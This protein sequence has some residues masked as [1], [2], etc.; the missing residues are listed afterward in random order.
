M[1]VSTA[2]VGFAAA[3]AAALSAL[4][5]AAAGDR[6]P[7]VDR[8]SRTGL[9]VTR[10]LSVAEGLRA[11]EASRF[12]LCLVDLADASG[13][14]PTIRAFRA[15]YPDIVVAGIMD[16]AQPLTAAEAIDAGVV[17]LL[18]WPFDERDIAALAANAR[19]GL[20]TSDAAA[21]ASDDRLFAHSPAMRQAVD[22]ARSAAI[23]RGGVLLIGE[24]GSGRERIA[25]A[26]HAWSPRA[27]RPFVTVACGAGSPDELE[28]RLFGVPAD[29]QAAQSKGR[30]PD[31]VGKTGAVV[32]AQ[33]GTL[34]LDA[35]VDAPARVQAKLVR[36]SRDG[37]ALLVDE[38]TTIDFDLRLVAA[39]E[40]GVE[41]ALMEGRLRRDLFER[42]SAVQI[43]VPPLRRRREDVPMLA[44]HLLAG[45]RE[46]L[47][48]PPQRFSRAALALL[49]ALPWPGNGAELRSL[50]ETLVRAVDRPVIQL[51]DLL[52]FVRLDGVSPRVD[53][54][55]TLRDARARFERDWISAVLMKHQGRVGDAAHALG[56]QRTNLYRKVRQL[57]VAR[58]LLARKA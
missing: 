29:R 9:S 8:L 28:Q 1:T 56:I 30:T 50:V 51:D 55:G 57:K 16:P 4:Y 49:S 44:V 12:D 58:T 2:P 37:E 13:A 24:S 34:F 14:I 48:A 32:E 11:L 41:S 52:E 22:A 53:V 6:R 19:D 47:G 43:E 33:G 3:E 40:P 25:R 5:V 10:V 31:R 23:A 46:A 21:D 42:L 18:P 54:T 39:V 38:R 45:L 15:Q 35:I 7:V 26:I 27:D 36:L 20:T 17:D